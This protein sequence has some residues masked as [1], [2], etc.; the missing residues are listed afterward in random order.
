VVEIAR[1]EKPALRLVVSPAQA[2][3]TP[4]GKRILGAGRG[5]LR[6]PS[7]EEWEEIDKEW[8]K[9]FH[10]YDMPVRWA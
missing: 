7:D 5:E 1:A 4:K 8:R 10:R 9:S 6:V 2:A 3:E